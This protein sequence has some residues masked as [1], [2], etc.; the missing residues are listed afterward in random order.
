MLT[1]I[2]VAKE[3]FEL[4]ERKSKKKTIGVFMCCKTGSFD[5]R[6]K[7]AKSLVKTSNSETYLRLVSF[8]VH[9]QSPFLAAFQCILNC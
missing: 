3:V 4:D 6:D 7:R 1:I 2:M 8:K 5:S 9:L